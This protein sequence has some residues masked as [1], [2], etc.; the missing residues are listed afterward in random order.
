MT[1]QEDAVTSNVNTANDNTIQRDP[2]IEHFLNLDT[3]LN[4]L[5]DFI[6]PETFIAT[7]ELETYNELKDKYLRDSLSKRNKQQQ[8]KGQTTISPS[9]IAGVE[10]I[11]TTSEIYRFLARQQS[12]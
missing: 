11:R 7:D 9:E 3:V 8:N 10:S 2:K 6:R 4:S 12:N 1:D 5:I